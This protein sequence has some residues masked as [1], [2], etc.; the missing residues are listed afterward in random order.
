MQ[1]APK[2]NCP[3]DQ[4]K[5]CRQLECGW[6]VQLRG[7]HPQSEQEIDEYGCAVAWLP[8]LLCENSQMQRQTGA[9]VESLRNDA[10]L[11]N[12]QALIAVAQAITERN[13]LCYSEEREHEEDQLR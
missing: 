7:K 10:V 6:F 5:P 4:F 9:A 2:T 13:K 11:K 12:A 1:I 8:V 3:L